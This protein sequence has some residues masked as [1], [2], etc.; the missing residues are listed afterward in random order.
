MRHNC[1][2]FNGSAAS[3]ET[4]RTSQ[5]QM[6]QYRVNNSQ[7]YPECPP[8]HTP[9]TTHHGYS[10]REFVVQVAASATGWLLIQRSPYRECVCVC[11]RCVCSR[12]CGF[13]SR[14]G[15]G[16]SSRVL[17]VQVAVSATGW[18]LIQRSPYLVCVCVCSRDCGFESR[19]G[20][21]YSSRVLA[22]QV[23]ALRRANHSYRWVPT[24]CVCVVRVF[25]GL[26][27]RISLRAWIFVSC[28]CCAGS[29]LCDGLITHTEESLPCV[30]VC[31]PGIAGSNPTEG[32]DIR[33]VY[34]LCR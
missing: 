11:V 23:A 34:L 6:V 22:V 31:V 21:G 7:I 19:R 3:Q 1:R 4:P 26:R 33:L 29:C 18:S 17:A 20:Y 9:P 12:D 24:V 8:P 5:N 15:H 30:S 10:S 13:E 25:P 16:Y 32:M 2:Q 27:V 14:R 28:I